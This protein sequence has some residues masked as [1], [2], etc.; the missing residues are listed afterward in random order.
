MMPASLVLAV[1]LVAWGPIAPAPDAASSGAPPSP[2]GATA[3]RGGVGS[4]PPSSSAP[5]APGQGRAAPARPAPLVSP[6]IAKAPLDVRATPALVAAPAP[7]DK[8]QERTPLH[9]RWQFWA[10][11]GGL[12]ATAIAVTVAVTRPGPRPYTG[13]A[14]PF[15]VTFP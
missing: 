6:I 11:A 12:F 9:K 15:F 13:N 2:A 14:G 7:R 10:I 8:A 5:V 4:P 3:P 1:A